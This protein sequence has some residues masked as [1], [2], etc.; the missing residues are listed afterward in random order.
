MRYFTKQSFFSVFFLSAILFFSAEKMQAQA[1]SADSLKAQFLRDWDRAKD[2][3]LDY[4]KTMPADKYS[5]RPTD[6]IRN[7]AQ[8]MLHL[9]QGNSFLI[10]MAT[11]KPMIL[12]DRELGERT[13]AQS[14]DSVTYYVTASYDFVIKCIKE[15][16]ASKYLELTGQDNR[17]LPRYVIIMKTFEHQTHHRGQS[18]IYIRLAGIKPPNERL[19]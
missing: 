7:F 3:T 14:K 4:L 9:A 12:A 1:F 5:L 10:S 6:S 11:G 2:Y 16:D 8:Q 13:S 17:K 18:T 15:L 19:F